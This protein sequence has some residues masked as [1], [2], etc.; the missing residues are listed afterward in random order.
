MKTFFLALKSFQFLREIDKFNVEPVSVQEL[1]RKC[2]LKARICETSINETYSYWVQAIKIE[3][4][5]AELQQES[6]A[7]YQSVAI[8]NSCLEVKL[9]WVLEQLINEA[10]QRPDYIN[11]KNVLPVDEPASNRFA[12]DYLEKFFNFTRESTNHNHIA[13]YT[14]LNHDANKQKI[15]NQY[16]EIIEWQNQIIKQSPSDPQNFDIT[17]ILVITPVERLDLTHTDYLEKSFEI[18]CRVV[19]LSNIQALAVINPIIF[20]Q[21]TLILKSFS[22]DAIYQFLSTTIEYTG[23]H[24]YPLAS[25][26]DFDVY[27]NIPL[28]CKQLILDWDENR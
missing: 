17:L 14:P 7:F 20:T 15:A 13:K 5:V 25:L 9:P 4:L 23:G 24:E 16:F 28:D 12:D 18:S 8:I 6:F 21:R 22:I 19:S 2:W 10:N 26:G 11:I 27:F 3:L 1:G